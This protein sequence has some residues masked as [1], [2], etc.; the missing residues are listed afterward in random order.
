[1]PGRAGMSASSSRGIDPA[2]N[3]DAAETTP[4]RPFGRSTNPA[5]RAD[6][7]LSPAP[8]Y[9]SDAASNRR[10]SS[11]NPA[12]PQSTEWLFALLTKRTPRFLMSAASSD[13][14]AMSTLL[15]RGAMRFVRRSKNV[16]SWF[17]VAKSASRTRRSAPSIALSICG[18]TGRQYNKSP[19][20]TRRNP[21]FTVAGTGAG[22]NCDSGSGI[23]RGSADCGTCEERSPTRPNA[24]KQ[25]TRPKARMSNWKEFARVEIQL[26]CFDIMERHDARRQHTHLERIMSFTVRVASLAIAAIAL[27]QPLAAQSDPALRAQ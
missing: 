11:S 12:A 14:P 18:L 2:E 3:D 10:S 27:T 22:S 24:T 4:M 21:S 7:R 16:P 20:V 19:S 9:G 5:A 1:M 8:E 25:P 13:G 15:S 26:A 17:A 6:A 23:Q